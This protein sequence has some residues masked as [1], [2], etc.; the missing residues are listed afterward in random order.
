MD[1]QTA[2]LVKAYSLLN[3]PQKK[4][5]LDFIAKLNSATT[6]QRAALEE[7]FTKATTINFAPSPTGCPV[8]G[9]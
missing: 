8:C 3:G 4:E 6:I 9:R 5:F 2:K 1:Q 7:H